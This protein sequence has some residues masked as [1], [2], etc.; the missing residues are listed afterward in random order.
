MTPRELRRLYKSAKAKLEMAN[1]IITDQT[2]II[3]TYARTMSIQE[4]QVICLNHELEE[5]TARRKRLVL[6]YKTMKQ[7]KNHD[8]KAWLKEID[9][10][11]KLQK[12]LNH[13]LLTNI[14]QSI[15]LVAITITLVNKA[16]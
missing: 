7:E 8:Y 12:T 16:F 14:I 4:N 3:D 11:N 10:S 5:I 15:V 9:K 2:D 13:S 1:K 6:K